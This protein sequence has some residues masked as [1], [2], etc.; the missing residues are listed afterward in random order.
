MTTS[1]FGKTDSEARAK[2]DAALAEKGHTAS[3]ILAQAYMRGGT[4]IDAVNRRIAGYERRRDAI[5]KEAGTWT[6]HLRRR[7]EQAT[8]AII[9]GEFTDATPEEGQ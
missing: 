8:A 2:I 4:Q 6:E 5:L 3:A 9:D 1:H 7:M